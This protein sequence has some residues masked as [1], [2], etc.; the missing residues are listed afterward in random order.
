MNIHFTHTD[1]ANSYTEY[2]TSILTPH[3]Y[4]GIKSIYDDCKTITKGSGNNIVIFQ[5]ALKAIS[6]WEEQTKHDEF[7]RLNTQL[8]SNKLQKITKAILKSKIRVLLGGKTLNEELQTTLDNS[9]LSIKFVHEIYLEIARKLYMTPHLMT[10][11]V[12][13]LERQKNI[14]TILSMIE[15]SINRAIYKI[16][17]IDDIADEYFKNDDVVEND[18][19]NTTIQNTID[20]LSKIIKDNVKES[21]S[22]ELEKI[23]S[24]LANMQGGSGNLSDA[25]SFVSRNVQEGGRDVDMASSGLQEE[26]FLLTNG[27]V[28]NEITSKQYGG[29]REDYDSDKSNKSFKSDSFKSDSSKIINLDNDSVHVGG[30]GYIY[31]SDSADENFKQYGGNVVNPNP[32]QNQQDIQSYPTTLQPPQPSSQTSMQPSMQP[33]QLTSSVQPS[34]QQSQPSMQQSQPSIQ[35]SIQPT[36]IGGYSEQSKPYIENTDDDNDKPSLTQFGGYKPVEELGAVSVKPSDFLS[37]SDGE[38]RKIKLRLDGGGFGG[39]SLREQRYKR[40]RNKFRNNN[41]ASKFT[42]FDENGLSER[43]NF[44]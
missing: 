36:Q 32:P 26:N 16:I 31:G 44:D 4:D 39:S 40:S 20:N 2:L 17:P 21:I 11:D 35:T 9:E 18:L 13:S 10:C 25:E 3:I 22:T 8:Q 6:K 19:F 28:K 1:T 14:N 33:P 24:K 30:D 7:N 15:S 37:D 5:N 29:D 27:S 12:N 34:V 41:V 42:F 23:E 38:T 43:E